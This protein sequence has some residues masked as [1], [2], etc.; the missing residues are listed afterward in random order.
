LR[1]AANAGHR[2]KK[3]QRKTK[4]AGHFRKVFYTLDMME[5]EKVIH[6]PPANDIPLAT[7]FSNLT[8]SL[9]FKTVTATSM[10][11]AVNILDKG[12]HFLK[13]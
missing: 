5:V 11:E 7:A 6:I 9:N 2:G 10:E 13:V 8:G 3:A 1:N 4:K 12:S